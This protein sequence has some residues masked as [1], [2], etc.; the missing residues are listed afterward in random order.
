MSERGRAYSNVADGHSCSEGGCANARNYGPTRTDPQT[1]DINGGG[2]I[3]NRGRGKSPLPRRHRRVGKHG[4]Q[5][6]SLQRPQ[7]VWHHESWGVHVREGNRICWY[8]SGEKRKA[9][10]R[11]ATSG[12][13]C[14]IATRPPAIISLDFTARSP[15]G[16]RR[17]SC[18][19]GEVQISGWAMTTSALDKALAEL[20]PDR[21]V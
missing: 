14:A 10:I 9:S 12:T 11:H 16:S 21:E 15:D 5:Y 13:A 20:G 3:L 8:A 2:R 17:G 6:L 18:R 1:Q 4:I 7:G 19:P